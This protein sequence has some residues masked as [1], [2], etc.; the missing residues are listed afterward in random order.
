MDARG[1]STLAGIGVGGAPTSFRRFGVTSW[2]GVPF[3]SLA[4]FLF[5]VSDLIVDFTFLA[6]S[7]LDTS[8]G[9]VRVPE[10]VFPQPSA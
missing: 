2:G 9:V 4:C 5:D 8:T 10:G 3:S 6:S 7:P 1:R